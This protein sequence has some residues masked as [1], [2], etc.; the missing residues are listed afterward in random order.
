MYV[1]G[2]G[3]GGGSAAPVV[4]VYGGI[5]TSAILCV[6]LVCSGFR[7]VHG[8]AVLLT[9]SRRSAHLSQYLCAF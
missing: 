3:R 5:L 2:R 7:L 1:S 8:G 9:S 4:F 6:F